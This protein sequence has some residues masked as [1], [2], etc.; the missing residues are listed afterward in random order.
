MVLFSVVI[1]TYNA[2][3]SIRKCVDS[4]LSQ[5]FREFEIV[6]IDD[7]SYDGTEKILDT[8]AENDERIKVFHIQNSGVSA[9]RRAGIMASTGEYVLFVDS[10]DTI[11]KNLL[12]KLQQTV[13]NSKPDI[14]RYQA[15]LLGDE[16][17]KDHNR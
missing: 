4:V 5:T 13:M 6:I 10:D 1:P 2:K 16:S 7:G 8:Y 14:I 15:N 11:E 9:A 12:E 17:H 3:P